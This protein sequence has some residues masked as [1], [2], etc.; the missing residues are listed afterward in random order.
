MP[1]RFQVAAARMRYDEGV[2]REGIVDR[3]L[4]FPHG[5]RR[6]RQQYGAL[7]PPATARGPHR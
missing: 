3:M 1:R 4:V 5:G 7:L 6:P 2:R